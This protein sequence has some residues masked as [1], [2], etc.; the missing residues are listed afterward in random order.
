VERKE[1]LKRKR[2][3][4][5]PGGITYERCP[6]CGIPLEVARLEWDLEGGVINDPESGRRM[7]L[8]GP[9]SMDS[10][11]GD[12]EAELGGSIPEVV[13]EAQRKYIKSRIVGGQWVHGRT[14]FNRL[15]AMR[16]LGN[17]TRFEANEKQLSVT[18]QNSC[19]PLLVLGM[20]QAIYETALGKE[21]SIYEWKLGEDGDFDF[22][23]TLAGQ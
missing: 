2:Y 19:M 16:G 3:D 11:L 4:F 6:E 13:V 18:I 9:T 12:L 1:W 7:A 14:T 22:T 15:C 10:V 5:K 17:I 8:I 21:N 20:A 23:V